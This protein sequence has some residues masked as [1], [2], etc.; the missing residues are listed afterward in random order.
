[1]VKKIVPD[2][3]KIKV[4]RE[5]RS[6]FKSY[7]SVILIAALAVTL[8]TGIWANYRDFQ[9]K[10]NHIYD[11]SS[12]ADGMLTL[13]S[14]DDEALS[15]VKAHTDVYQTRIFLSAKVDGKSV[16]IATFKN[17]DVLN[18]P[19]SASSDIDDTK[20]FADENFASNHKTGE[21]FKVIT[22]INAVSE[23]ELT[24]SGTM[25]HPESLGNSI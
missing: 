12:M 18:R 11:V 10:L 13:K 6:N 1:M 21:I 7:L 15:A 8:F 4:A 23:V 14:G 19:Y 22:D 5:I 2:V 24:L 20:V 25:V 16:Y 9:D 17:S 3:L